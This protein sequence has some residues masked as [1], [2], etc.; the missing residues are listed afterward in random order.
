M[1]FGKSRFFKQQ[2]C[3]DKVAGEQQKEDESYTN[4][5]EN[6]RGIT[7]ISLNKTLRGEY[8]QLQTLEKIAMVLNIPISDL[9]KKNDFGEDVNG[10]I[11]VKGTIYEIHSFDD[12]E[13]VLKMKD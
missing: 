12:L 3:G 9:F 5:R 2:P 1:L 11:K 13:K 7:D 6:Q 4:C 10:Y 8:P